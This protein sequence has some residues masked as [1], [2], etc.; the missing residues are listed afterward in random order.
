MSWIERV[1]VMLNTIHYGP[2]FHHPELLAGGT[3][4][5]HI[6]VWKYA[7]ALGAAGNKQ[8]PED[9]WKLQPPSVVSGPVSDLAVSLSSP[10]T[11]IV[12]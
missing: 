6:A 2:C 5:G 8:E 1:F 10:I 4:T 11:V 3:D 12:M 9:R 7:P